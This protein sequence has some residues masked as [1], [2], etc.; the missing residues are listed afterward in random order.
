V[1]PAR[2]IVAVLFSSF[3]APASDGPAES[4]D[5]TVYLMGTEVRL[6]AFAST[7]TA[8]LAVVN[9]A[10]LILEGTE[11]QLSTWRNDSAISLLNHQPPGRSRPVDTQ[12]CR[13]FDVLYHW[14]R[15]SAG[16]FDPAIGSLIEAWRIHGQG[17]I[18]SPARLARA[19]E[20]SGLS[21]LDFD[22]VRCTLTRRAEVR[23]DVGAWGKGEALDRVKQALPD[24]PW[25]IDLGGQIAVNGAA[26]G[27]T[28]WDVALAD[29]IAR[30]TPLMS[31]TLSTGSL[32]TSGGSERDLVVNGRRVA[33][34]LDP[35]TGQ[36]AAF[37]G[38]VTVW[39]QRALVADIL[40]TALYVM[41]PRE[42]L[43]WAEDR[44]IAA[45][46]LV[47]AAPGRAAVRMTS[48]FK[49]HLTVD[50]D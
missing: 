13:T 41:G 35:R 11:R 40:S 3:L 24:V 23:I 45:C 16:A 38:T 7:K 6:Q 49:R 47:P 21:L 29:P 14:Q 20:T 18:P 19:R 43:S 37:T 27:H 17:R 4:V 44:G 42:G 15:E 9:Q 25:L 48:F 28:G 31:V 33:H 46:F 34:H 50:H 2:A 30:Q 32:S 26:P 12:L 1:T 39:H 10:L 5:R 8:A 22:A 36:P